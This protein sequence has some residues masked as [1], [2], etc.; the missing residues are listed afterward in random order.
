VEEA[1]VEVSAGAEEEE[2]VE[3]VADAGDERVNHD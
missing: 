1:A 3:A 2:C